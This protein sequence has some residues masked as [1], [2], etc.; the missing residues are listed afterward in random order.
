M[1]AWNVISQLYRACWFGELAAVKAPADLGVALDAM[2]LDEQTPLMMAVSQ[3]HVEVVSFL[4]KR[5]ADI[6]RTDSNVKS[7]L[8]IA[9]ETESADMLE[10]LLEVG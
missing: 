10:L 8:H 7:L 3:R 9:I 5:G 4:L 6:Q 1:I 2:H